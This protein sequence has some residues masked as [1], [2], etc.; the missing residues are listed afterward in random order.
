MARDLTILQRRVELGAVERA[1][2]GLLT[3]RDAAVLA[4]V[5]RLEDY[6]VRLLDGSQPWSPYAWR[7]DR[8]AP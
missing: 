8:V 5:G 2:G 7:L 4:G 1:V 6:H 3:C